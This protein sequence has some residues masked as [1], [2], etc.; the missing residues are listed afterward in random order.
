L[1]IV[2]LR[3]DTLTHP[4][5]EM[6]EAMA[7]AEVGDDVYGEDPTVNLFESLAAEKMGKEAA[8]FVPTGSMGNLI[9]IMAHTSRGDQVVLESE[10][11]IFHH[12]MGALCS[13]AGVL[14]RLVSTKYGAISPEALKAVISP[15]FP[16]TSLVCLENTHNRQGGTVLTEQDTASVAEVAHQHG[17]RVHLDGARIFNAAVALGVD[18][19]VLTRHVDSVMFC[20]SKGLSAPVGSVVC[21]PKDFVA[22]ARSM[23]KLVG[24]GMRQA[25]VLAAC[26]VV[27]LKTMIPRLGEDHRRARRLAEAIAAGGGLGVDLARVQS[28]MVVVNGEPLG[29][30]YAGLLRELAARGVKGGARPPSSVRLI[31]NRH[32][33]DEDID[34]VIAAVSD[35]NRAHSRS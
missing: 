34:Q 31:V 14:P 1:K 19:R 32:H 12:E 16:R 17:L 30:D 22:R 4:T 24:G 26:G 20:I 21:G 13:V 6:R 2:D 15:S 9:S 8:V 35:L 10:A 23:R 3:S 7:R 29:L 18:A 5:P 33:G 28:N 27:A 11:H 25:G